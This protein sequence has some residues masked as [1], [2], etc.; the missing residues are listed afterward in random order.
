M[1]RLPGRTAPGSATG[2][3][4]PGAM[5]VAP[6]TIDSGSLA[7]AERHGREAEAVRARVPLDRQQLAGDD[8]LPVG[9]PALD[10]LDLHAQERQPL[11][12]LLRA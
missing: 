1:R 11:G 3:R 7:V 9:A 5:L 6:H 4:W 8:V 12:E 2:M 10:V